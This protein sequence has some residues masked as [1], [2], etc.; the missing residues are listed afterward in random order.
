MNVTIPMARS[1]TADPSGRRYL[2][3]KSFY[4]AINRENSIFTSL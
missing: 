4:P 1:V 2:V 3:T